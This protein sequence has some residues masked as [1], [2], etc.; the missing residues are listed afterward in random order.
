MTLPVLNRKLVLQ[1]PERIADEA[2]GY[3]VTWTALGT[4][5][6]QISPGSG[7]EVAAHN[8][9]RSRVPLRIVVRAAPVGASSRPVPGQRFVEGS[10]VYAITA[11]TEVDRTTHYLTCHAEEEVIA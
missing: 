3:V 9:P 11:V 5:W 2:G 4:L 1:E 8:L 6:A 7:R 10:R